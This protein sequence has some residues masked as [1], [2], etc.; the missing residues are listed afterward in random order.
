MIRL[1]GLGSNVSF[2][3]CCK[4]KYY[5]SRTNQLRY[6]DMVLDLRGVLNLFV[7]KIGSVL[8]EVTEYFECYLSP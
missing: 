3:G 1:F 7:I 5:S 6:A 4:I 8:T 2:E